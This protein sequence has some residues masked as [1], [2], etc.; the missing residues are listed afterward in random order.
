MADIAFLATIVAF[1]ILCVGYV[2]LCGRIIGPTTI[3]ADDE[4]R[5]DASSGARSSGRMNAVVIASVGA[6]LADN[7]VALGLT[8]R[9][10]R[11][12][13]TRPRLPREVLTPCPPPTSSSSSR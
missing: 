13:R 12:P 2:Q 5:H 7:L 10:H 3:A 6:S 8:V 1:F 4:R 9:G 11:V